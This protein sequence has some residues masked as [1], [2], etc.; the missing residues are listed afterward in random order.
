MDKQIKSLSNRW[1]ALILTV[2]LGFLLIGVNLISQVTLASST[3]SVW[4][5]KPLLEYFVLSATL[6]ERLKEEVG[7]SDTQFDI[8]RQITLNEVEQFRAM[9]EE[10]KAIILDENLSLPEKRSQI[11]ASGHNQRVLDAVDRSNRGLEDA[12]GAETYIEL[13]NW[14]ERE[15]VSERDQ[16]GI[17]GFTPQ[18]PS[19]AR[20]YSIFATRY[21]SNG[22]YTVALPDACVKFANQGKHLCDGS[23]Y[24]VGQD[25]SVKLAYQ[26]SVTVEVLDSGPWNVDDN[27]WSLVEDPQPRRLFPDLPLG[28]PEAQAAYFDDYNGGEDQFGR[29]VTAPFGI[30]L[31]RDVSIDIGLQPGNNDWIDVTFLWTDGWEYLQAEVVTLYGPTSLHPAYTGDMCVTAWHRINGYQR[32]VPAYLTLNVNEASQSTNWA[33][34]YPDLPR[35][36]N[37]QVRA[38]IPDH[39]AIDW[40]CPDKP[41]PIDTSDARY[42]IHYTNDQQKT[43]SR[44]QGPLTNMWLDLGTYQFDQGSGGGVVLTDLNGEL[45]LS[46]TIAFSAMQFRMELPSLPTPTPSPTPTPTPTPLPDPVIW[47]GFGLSE[48]NSS[49]TIPLG[50]RYLQDPGL[51]TAFI[52]VQYD[53]AVVQAVGCLVDPGVN[54]E[55]KSCSLNSVYTDTVHF[56]LASSTGVTGDPLVAYLTF[57]AIGQ[58]GEASKLEVFPEIFE[59]PDGSPIPVSAHDGIVCITPCQNI[60]YL[61]VIARWYNWE[62]P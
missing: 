29:T 21:D 31:D 35:S 15:W 51:G 57:Q 10:S 25:Y 39:P 12:L 5:N 50:A 38:Y 45:N 36:G 41:I 16:H 62:A 19:T 30:D 46:H 4:G 60:A 48:Q 3:E 18:G 37:Y 22:V 59:E 52:D 28:M 23:G 20:T 53:P 11:A 40:L 44:N 54:F 26:S 33:S 8:L 27:Y 58:P 61:P 2:F 32:N 47:S 56:E 24:E 55:S 14:I 6:S 13:V 1:Y 17:L 34:W 43:V 9:E 7:L 49:V 42:T